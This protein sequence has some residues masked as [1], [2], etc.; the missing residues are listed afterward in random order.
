MKRKHPLIPIAIL[1]E[2]L[3]YDASSG[4]ITWLHNRYSHN[5]GLAAVAGSIAG[6]I[7]V[8]GYRFI[9]IAHHGRDLAHRIAWAMH[10]GEWPNGDVDHINMDRLDN[11]IANLR[12]ASR[13][14]NMSNRG[15]TARNRLKV[16]GVE[17]TRAG[18]YAVKIM[19][20]YKKYH[21]GTAYSLEE[22]KKMHAEAVEKLHGKF[23][24][25]I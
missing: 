24:R 8:T 13:S 12:L 21:I 3:A 2:V 5:N 10:Y 20:D 11:R 1:T 15:A 23:A 9:S 16:K 4:K 25:S 14:Q 6:S 7:L 19:K 17:L 22:A 18:N